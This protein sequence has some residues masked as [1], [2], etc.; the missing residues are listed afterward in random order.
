MI[1]SSIL[2]PPANFPL[3]IQSRP[4]EPLEDDEELSACFISSNG[5]VDEAVVGG[6]TE[7]KSSPHS[8]YGY[9]ENIAGR[10]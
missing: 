8:S 7:S 9:I 3:S 4:D 6:T 1:S 2:N 5:E 10:L